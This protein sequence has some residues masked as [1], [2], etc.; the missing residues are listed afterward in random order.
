M[1]SSFLTLILYR[2][3]LTGPEGEA[4]LL[5]LDLGDVLQLQLVRPVEAVGHLLVQE[6]LLATT[7]VLD[8]GELAAPDHQ[9]LQLVT[10]AGHRLPLVQEILAGK[11]NVETSIR[12]DRQI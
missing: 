3:S 8:V 9:G 11:V 2:H 6:D 4:E 7:R 12:S 1:S 10:A 5:G